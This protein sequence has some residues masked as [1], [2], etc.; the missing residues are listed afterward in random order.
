MEENI[1]ELSSMSKTK[2][3]LN[4]SCRKS[5]YKYKHK[6]TIMLGKILGKFRNN[7]RFKLHEDLEYL[8]I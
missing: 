8:C 6:V 2:V 3:E 5:H 4:K 1:E 7:A